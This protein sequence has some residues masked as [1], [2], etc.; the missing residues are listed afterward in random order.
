MY[1]RFMS[2]AKGVQRKQI[3]DFVFIDHRTDIA[4]VATV[5]EAHGEDI[6]AIGRYYLD[7]KTNFAEVAFTVRDEWQQKGIGT[8]LLKHLATIAHRNGI[9]GFT[10]EVLLENKAMQSVLNKSEFRVTSEPGEDAYSFRVEF[11]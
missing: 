11:A 8:F 9:T 6:V 4:I 5:P 1:Y 3:Q 2:S 10:A 7:E